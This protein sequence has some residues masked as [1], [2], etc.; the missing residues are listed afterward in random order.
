MVMP[1]TFDANV[2][3]SLPKHVFVS[4]PYSGMTKN[5]IIRYNER[6]EYVPSVNNQMYGHNNN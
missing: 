6:F 3:V 5:G 4:G 1:V 2:I